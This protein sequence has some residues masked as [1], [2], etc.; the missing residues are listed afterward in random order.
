MS[1][2]NPLMITLARES[3]HMTQAALAR[4]LGVSQGTIS[5]LEHGQGAASPELLAMIA[6]VLGYEPGLFFEQ[7]RPT[8]LPVFFHRK[9]KSLPVTALRAMHAD[10]EIRRI[11]LRKLLQSVEAPQY[12]VPLIDLRKERLTPAEIAR[13]L[14]AHWGIPRGP[15]DNM[16]A[17]LEA[18]GVVVFVV[19]FGSH[20]IDG[21][22]IYSPGEQLP[23]V[24]FL[25][26]RSSGE[27][28]RFTAAHELMHII[29]HYCL[30]LPGEEC[31]TEADE[32]ASEFLMPSADIRGFLGNVSLEDLANLKKRW[33]VSMAALLRKA[34]T[35]GRTSPWKA[36]KLWIEMSSL[37]YKTREP[38]EFPI[39]EPSLVNEIIEVHL[40][41][42]QFSREELS[43]IIYVDPAALHSGLA[44]TG[45]RLRLVQA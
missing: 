22:S 27:R 1:T 9:R 26:S 5:K 33:K 13:Q 3:R 11:Q 41:D 45:G 16:T 24:V 7:V 19:D 6:G 12:R 29:A 30:D 37:G 8:E 10:F 25:N 39:E 20:L 18:A 2:V 21:L 28:T 42:L 35:L 14:R 15:I 31:E 32:F 40:R 38:N 23:P 4:S 44:P 34:V 36:K 43:Q 17:V